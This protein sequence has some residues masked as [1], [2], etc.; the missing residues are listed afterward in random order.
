[1][2]V[3]RHASVGV[4]LLAHP[5]FRVA[6]LGPQ[7]A[8]T[9]VTELDSLG[10]SMDVYILPSPNPRTSRISRHGSKSETVNSG[11]VKFDD[12]I[13]SN[14][15]EIIFVFVKLNIV[16]IWYSSSIV[17]MVFNGFHY[18]KK[19]ILIVNTSGK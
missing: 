1:M 7:L 15:F 12:E 3:F 8:A 5:R 19:Y 9:E 18:N 17:S 14:V 11:F 13:E 4:C 10:R 16:I 6:I 2:Q